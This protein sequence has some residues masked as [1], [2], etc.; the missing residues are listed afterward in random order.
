MFKKII[1]MMYNI[2]AGCTVVTLFEGR[3]E[4]ILISFICLIITLLTHYFYNG[5][6]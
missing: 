2:T 6:E 3:S 5:G 1:G 4:A